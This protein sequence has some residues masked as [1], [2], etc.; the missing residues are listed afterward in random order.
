MASW[1]YKENDGGG[2]D[3]YGR[4]RRKMMDS[5]IYIYAVLAQSTGIKHFLWPTLELDSLQWT[6]SH[7]HVTQSLA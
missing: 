1:G 5:Y 3:G 6:L 2:G 4:R 7:P